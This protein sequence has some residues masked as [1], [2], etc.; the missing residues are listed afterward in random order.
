MSEV[1]K[2]P[3]CGREMESGYVKLMEGTRWR[4]EEKRRGELLRWGGIAW[5]KEYE[6]Y[7][8]RDCQLLL[9]HY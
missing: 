7:L 4:T 8:C 3:S 5:P 1:K 2:C 6:A 9:L